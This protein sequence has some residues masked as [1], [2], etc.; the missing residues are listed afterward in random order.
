MKSLSR[1]LIIVFS[2]IIA[3][4][5]AGHTAAGK[6]HLTKMHNWHCAATDPIDPGYSKANNPQDDVLLFLA[7][8]DFSID[9]YLS[10]SFTFLNTAYPDY[11]LQRRMIQ[12]DKEQINRSALITG[13]L[14]IYLLHHTLLI[15]FT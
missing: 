12:P 4:H 9:K 10:F 8:E 11:Q 5:T 3:G 1:I 6:P 14:P 15:P 7:E 2:F 13:K